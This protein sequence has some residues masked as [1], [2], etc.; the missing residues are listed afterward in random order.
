[1]NMGTHALVC[2]NAANLI[3]EDGG[4]LV[5]GTV[6]AATVKKNIAAYTS[7]NDG[8][9]LISSP[10][11]IELG[12]AGIGLTTETTYD[13]YYLNEGTSKWI[14]FK[15]N[16]GNTNPGFSIQP[17]IGYLYANAANTTL[18]FRGTLQPYSEAGLEVSLTKVGEG[19]NLVGNPYPFNA[20][21]NKPYYVI[22]GRTVEV[23]EGSDP[24]PTC[25]GIIVKATAANDKITFRRTSF[26][27]NA[28]N[29]GNIE[30]VLAQAVTNRGN[31][32]T[33]DNAIV[34]FNEGSQLPKFY[35]GEQNAILYIPQGTEEYAIVSSNGQGEMPVNF[36]TNEN[37][38]YTLTVNLE[39]VEMNYLHLI[40]N[41]TGADVDLLVNPSYTFDARTT[42]YASRFRLLFSANGV[43]ENDNDI[44]NETFAFVSN[45]EIIVNGTGTVQLIDALGRILLTQEVTP[46]SSL[47]TPNYSGVYV[48]RLVGEKVK[49]QKIVV[50]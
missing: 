47:P 8:W 22:N 32:E 13:L 37:G 36:R 10:V 7:A 12:A 3:I 4:Q 42:D 48:L 44:E 9:N 41:M 23:Y 40:D 18:N 46:N 25:T 15:A 14:N 30:L 45:G 19:W 38:Q 21:V 50:K 33:L 6:V 31:A 49:T 11:N 5:T 1:M 17:H 29:N 27:S 2:D 20:Y 16:E 34:S 35:F 43:E 26:A 28:I 39:N 24:V